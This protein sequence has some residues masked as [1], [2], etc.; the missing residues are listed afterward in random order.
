MSRRS[1]VALTPEEQSKYLEAAKTVILCTID[2][3]G[4]PHAVAM[5]FTVENGAVLMT[6][7]GKSQKAVNIRRNPK[8]ALLVESG[9]VYDALKGLM[10]RG[11]GEV[12]NDPDACV[13]VL[14]QVHR[15]MGGAMQPGIEE[16]M[17]VQAQ[18]RVLL[19]IT[20]EHVSSWDHSKLG[21]V[22]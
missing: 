15:K 7:Y 16:A 21:G 17:R 20:P 1:T 18:K 4:Y 19:R 5:W 13:G 10:I 8:V 6:T 14:T 3:R 22:Y 2:G 11:R 12:I 9:E